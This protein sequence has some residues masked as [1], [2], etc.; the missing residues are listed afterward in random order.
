MPKVRYELPHKKYFVPEHNLTGTAAARASNRS[1]H[2]TGRGGPDCGLE[3]KR[4]CTNR[5]RHPHEHDVKTAVGHIGPD[6]HDLNPRDH[7]WLAS[8]CFG[9][10]VDHLALCVCGYGSKYRHIPAPD[11]SPPGTPPV[12]WG[13]PMLD[14]CMPGTDKSGHSLDWGR[15]HLKYEDLYGPEGWC[16]KEQSAL[17]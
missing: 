6:K 2:G 14:N 1:S 17:Q 11:G 3:V 10:C 5:F 4:P 13:R 12:Q 15:P 7:G 16:N 8:R 9:H